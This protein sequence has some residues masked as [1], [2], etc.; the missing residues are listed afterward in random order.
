ML[1]K[2]RIP[3][4]KR[5]AVQIFIEIKQLITPSGCINADMQNHPNRA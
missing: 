3:L 1:K 4:K 2:K 5:F